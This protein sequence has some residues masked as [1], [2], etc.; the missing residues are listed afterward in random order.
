LVY[1]PSC[2]LRR[3]IHPPH[4]LREGNNMTESEERNWGMAAHLSTLSGLIIPFGNFLGPLVVWLV[5]KAE[6]PFVDYHGKEALNFNI[7]IFLAV[8]VSAILT[9]VL[10]GFVML[11][12][13]GLA[14]LILSIVAGIA[15]SKGEQYQ[16]PYILRLIK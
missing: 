14:W 9:I 1:L 10:I 13:V 4:Y 5:K 3:S 12:V 16:Y 2:P 6:S 7:T 15:A 11:I 8:I